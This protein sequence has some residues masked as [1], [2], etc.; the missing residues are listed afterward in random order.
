[1]SDMMSAA[2]QT[3]NKTRVYG[4][5]QILTA[6]ISGIGEMIWEIEELW[7][8]SE[9]I[10]MAERADGKVEKRRQPGGD[11]EGLGVTPEEAEKSRL[12]SWK[13]IVEL[14]CLPERQPIAPEIREW[15]V[16]NLMAGHEVFRLCEG[17]E[18][19][20][21]YLVAVLENAA[22][23]NTD[24]K[25]AAR[26]QKRRKKYTIMDD[27]EDKAE[28]VTS[29][30][31][32]IIKITVPRTIVVLRYHLGTSQRRGWSSAGLVTQGTSTQNG[33]GLEMV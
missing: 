9:L 17:D 21:R 14:L 32:Q 1:M 6:E 19:A 12:L 3:L 20:R 7:I 15:G 24:A 18:K 28:D 2:L 16:Q 11:A 27:G 26:E 4:G 33:V 10:K 31:P 8:V 13:N 5:H 29:T 23:N 25:V 30:V 22:G